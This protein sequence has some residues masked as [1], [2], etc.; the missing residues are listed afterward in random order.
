[1]MGNLAEHFGESAETDQETMEEIQAY[2]DKYA[3]IKGQTDRLGQ[4]WRNMPETPP[5]RITELPGFVQAHK[6]VPEQLEL[7]ELAEGFL[8]PCGDCHRT[9]ASGIFDK[10]LIHPG[11]GPKVWGG[12]S[13]EDSNP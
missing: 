5:L 4:L 3:L 11:Y 13:S 9:A 8:S 12:D 6:E 2:L 1:M 7:E 10:E